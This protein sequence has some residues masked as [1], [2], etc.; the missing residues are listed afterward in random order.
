MVCFS[1]HFFYLLLVCLLVCLLA[2]LFVC[3]LV[4]LLACL[5]GWLSLIGNHSL[6]SFCFASRKVHVFL[7]LLAW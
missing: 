4:C 3:L 5:F 1:E 7:C 6:F 2:C